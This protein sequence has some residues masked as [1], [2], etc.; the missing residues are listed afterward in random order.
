MALGRRVGR[1]AGA[2][3][4]RGVGPGRPPGLRRAVRDRRTVPEPRT[5]SEPRTVP[6]P[7]S[8][9]RPSAVR[10]HVPPAGC[11][12]SGPRPG[13]G[14]RPGDRRPGG[15]PGS[16]ATPWAWRPGNGSEPPVGPS[17][18]GSR[19]PAGRRG[20]GRR[21]PGAAARW[22]GCRRSGSR[23]A[24]SRRNAGARRDAGRRC[25]RRHRPRG[26]GRAAGRRR[27]REPGPARPDRVRH[28]AR[29]PWRRSRAGGP[30]RP[31]AGSLAE[32]RPGG[33][34][35]RSRAHA[36]VRCRPDHRNSGCSPGC[37]A[38]PSRGGAVPPGARPASTRASRTGG[39]ER[40]AVRARPPR[41]AVAGG[42][43]R[44][45]RSRPRVRDPGGA[46]GPRS[47]PPGRSRVE[48]KPWGSHRRRRRVYP[49]RA[50]PV[51]GAAYPRWAGEWPG[52]TRLPR[53]ADTCPVS[54]C[55]PRVPSTQAGAR[56]PAAGSAV[57]GPVV[58]TGGAGPVGAGEWRR[59][60]LPC[61][62]TPRFLVPCGPE[63][64]RASSRPWGAA[65]TRTGTRPP[66][67][68][69]TTG[70]PYPRQRIRIPVEVVPAC[71]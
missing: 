23:C 70:K 50:Y 57:R 40:W 52:R 33:P 32:G 29:T 53:P 61:S 1:R 66:A 31:A 60:A 54:R 44:S 30:A 12:G 9:V 4:H 2:T 59:A 45:D 8:V 6:A 65:V 41:G 28:R 55:R 14:C 39:A 21:R 48:R 5:V 19:P 56:C 69:V 7:G 20:S 34:P 58:W 27:A 13:A 18:S 24:G 67:V 63:A 25:P 47:L 3:G 15:R 10:C 26:S 46:G 51:P 64:V 36:R 71:A 11:R 16:G 37:S 42:V 17:G 22:P 68:A 38:Y 35:G 49:N 62:C 43:A